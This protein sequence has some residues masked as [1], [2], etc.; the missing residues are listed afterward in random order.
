VTVLY[1]IRAAKLGLFIFCNESYKFLFLT[2]RFPLL[3]FKANIQ[4]TYCNIQG[5]CSCYSTAKV[6]LESYY[7]EALIQWDSNLTLFGYIYSTAIV[8]LRSCYSEPLIQW[9]SN[10]TLF[11]TSTAALHL[12]Q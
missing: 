3:Y 4:F 7:S 5:Y 6:V 12:L 9:D 10:L 11:D 2:K 1:S 8:V